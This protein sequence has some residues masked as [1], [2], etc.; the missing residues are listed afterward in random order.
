M[1]NDQGTF[2]AYRNWVEEEGVTFTT[3]ETAVTDRTVENLATT[4]ADNFWRFNVGTASSDSESGESYECYD[5][6]GSVVIDFGELRDV[7]V[8]TVQFPRGVYPGV[9][10]SNPVFAATD[11]IEWRL[12]DD[13][14]QEIYASGL[15][16]S[17]VEIGYMVA[18]HET[19]VTIT[20]RKMEVYFLATSRA[21]DGFC[22]VGT[23]GA[24]PKVEPNVGF[25]YPAG[26][27]WRTNTENNRTPAG[28]LYTARFDP[29]R[30]WSLSFDALSNA[31]SLLFDE[32]VRFGGG[33]RQV[34][35]KR[36]DLPEGKNAMHAIQLR[37]R[38]IDS[39][40]ATL[41]QASF[42]FEEFI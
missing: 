9:S 1:A 19:P 3:D 24:W 42:T 31:E 7:D 25:A 12:L 16:D 29:L 41:R 8:M 5:A 11:K 23:V 37:G 20:A 15:V 21:D 10:E 34:F 22:D 33:A 13:L 18:Y 4:K 30:R 32:F 2:L 35:V 14:D 26:F 38:D 17:G 6:S 39:I 36:G 27:G 28:K 40:T